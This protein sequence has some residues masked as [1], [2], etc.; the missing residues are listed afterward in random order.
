MTHPRF[1]VVLL[2][3]VSA[4]WLSGCSSSADHLDEQISDALDDNTIDVTEADAL[5]VFVG[6]ESKE[7]SKDKKTSALLTPDGKL[8]ESALLAYIKRNRTYRKLAKE[9][10]TPTVN[11]SGSVASSKPMRLK[12]YL[13][14]SGSMFPYDA[15]AA[16]AHSNVP[17]T[18][19]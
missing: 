17:S 15:P 8:E 11:L 18:M 16:M 5:R 14:A 12:L 4:G 3:V 6:Q 1:F 13:E 19:C 2:L 9:G 7:L 10:K